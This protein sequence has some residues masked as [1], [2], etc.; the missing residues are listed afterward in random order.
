VREHGGRIFGSA[1]DG[2]LAEFPSAV[3]ALWLRP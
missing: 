3:Q 2:L 1:G